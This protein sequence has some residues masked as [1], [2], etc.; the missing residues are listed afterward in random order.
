MP[1]AAP[2]AFSGPVRFR[3]R[4]EPA[5]FLDASNANLH[6]LVTVRDLG[7]GSTETVLVCAILVLGSLLNKQLSLSLLGGHGRAKQDKMGRRGT[8]RASERSDPQ[9]NTSRAQNN[10]CEVHQGVFS[11]RTGSTIFSS[12]SPRNRASSSRHPVPHLSHSSLLLGL[13][14]RGLARHA[15]SHHDKCCQNRSRNQ[16][17]HFAERIMHRSRTNHEKEENK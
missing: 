13:F 9:L 12:P 8:V 10:L 7:S 1:L 2:P 5:D 6:R 3:L 4:R 14:L 16:L 17:V 11:F 15:H